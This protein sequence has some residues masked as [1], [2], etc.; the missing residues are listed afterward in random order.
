MEQENK[1]QKMWYDKVFGGRKSFQSFWASILG[2]FA[3]L[4][5]PAY[6]RVEVIYWFLGY[7]AGCFALMG[8]YNIQEHK[9]NNKK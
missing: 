9:A 3:Y 6:Q 4:L 2:M 1:P 8:F 5:I 7:W